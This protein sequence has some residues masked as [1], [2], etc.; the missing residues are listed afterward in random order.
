[1]RLIER[2]WAVAGRRPERAGGG[3]WPWL[4]FRLA[5]PAMA[6][7]GARGGGG[8]GGG[9]GGEGG[10]GGGRRGGRRAP[11]RERTP[12]SGIGGAD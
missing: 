11:T 1:M 2:R 7:R 3:R 5:G 6:G 10:G 4:L 8:E 12:P 9:G